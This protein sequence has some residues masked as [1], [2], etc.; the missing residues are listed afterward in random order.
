MY[1]VIRR[2]SLPDLIAAVNSYEAHGWKAIGGITVV[3]PMSEYETRVWVQAIR[4]SDAEIL[5][6]IDAAPAGFRD[7]A[8]PSD[9]ETKARYVYDGK[10]GPWARHGCAGDRYLDVGEQ[11]LPKYE[12]ITSAKRAGKTWRYL[13]VETAPGPRLVSRYRKFCST[14][15]YR[16]I[17][18]APAPPDAPDP[19]PM[20]APG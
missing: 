3:A 1:D 7:Q 8:E 15:I 5:E 11:G 19:L 6:A 9:A 10:I 14:N 17:V 2:Q 18:D 13:E 20:W 12:R 16:R 4:K